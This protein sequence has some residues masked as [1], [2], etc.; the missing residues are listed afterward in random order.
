MITISVRFTRSRNKAEICYIIIQVLLNYTF[1]ELKVLYMTEYYILCWMLIS[2]YRVLLLLIAAS[3]IYVISLKSA[4]SACNQVSCEW[5]KVV[6]LDAWLIE[7]VSVRT[8]LMMNGVVIVS[9]NYNYIHRAH[10]WLW[11]V[12]HRSRRF[13]STVT[14]TVFIVLLLFDPLINL[15]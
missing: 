8:W 10:R 3:Y 2:T 12:V 5:W 7:C 6:S 4:V 13:T 14:V 15:L 1:N 11:Y 9:R